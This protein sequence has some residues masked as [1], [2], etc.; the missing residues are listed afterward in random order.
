[1]RL[2]LDRNI[3]PA[4]GRIENLHVAQKSDEE[5]LKN[6]GLI[7]LIFDIYKLFTRGVTNRLT[8]LLDKE[9]QSEQVHFALQMFLF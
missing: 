6:Y 5:D 9:H 2:S 8:K 1:M 7:C 4:A 3:I